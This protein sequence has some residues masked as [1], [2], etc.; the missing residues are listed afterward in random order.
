[1]EKEKKRPTEE[2]RNYSKILSV[3]KTRRFETILQKKLR[4]C[5]LHH[6][7]VLY[8][9]GVIDNLFSF[10]TLLE[11]TFS[12]GYI[13]FLL[14][15]SVTVRNWIILL[16]VFNTNR[17]FYYIIDQSNFEYISDNVLFIVCDNSTVSNNIFGTNRHI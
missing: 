7:N 11:I 12:V 4:K 10:M 2:D 15:S 6:Q 3:F 16:R 13:I 9:V 8:A 14:Y 1:M 17:I 5:I